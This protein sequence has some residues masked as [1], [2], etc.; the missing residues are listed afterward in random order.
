[1]ET[2]VSTLHQLLKST[3]KSSPSL[4][5]HKRPSVKKFVKKISRRGHSSKHKGATPLLEH[6]VDVKGSI[7]K[8]GE[9]TEHTL[10]YECHSIVHS[11]IIHLFFFPSILFSFSYQLMS[12][13]SLMN[14]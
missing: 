1:M 10:C 6:K 14:G 5:K 9:V 7:L 4:H 2:Q 13:V 12:L 8:E 3:P 11:S